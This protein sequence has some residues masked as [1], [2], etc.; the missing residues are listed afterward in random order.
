[1]TQ[2]GAAQRKPGPQSVRLPVPLNG[3]AALQSAAVRTEW[4]EGMEG[5]PWDQ[6]TA[7]SSSSGIPQ[8]AKLGCVG[9]GRASSGMPRQVF[10]L[11]PSLFSVGGLKFNWKYLQQRGSQGDFFLLKEKQY[12]K[13]Q[14]W[15]STVLVCFSSRNLIYIQRHFILS[16]SI[17]LHCWTDLYKREEG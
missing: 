17:S 4:S 12:R 9:I 14:P 1:M 6:E 11:L 16:C 10:L 8:I 2:C 15:I 3:A 5:N 7:S 13:G